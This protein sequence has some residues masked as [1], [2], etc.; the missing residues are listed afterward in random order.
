MISISGV[1]SDFAVSVNTLNWLHPTFN[2][3]ITLLHM[4]RSSFL[5]EKKCPRKH[6]NIHVFYNHRYM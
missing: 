6:G 2:Y 4:L 1:Y 5:I 3:F